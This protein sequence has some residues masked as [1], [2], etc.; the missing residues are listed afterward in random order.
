MADFDAIDPAAE[1][2]DS[3]SLE[4]YIQIIEPVIIRG[5]GNIT[6]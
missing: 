3:A 6:V 2:E 4:S 5:T 1:E